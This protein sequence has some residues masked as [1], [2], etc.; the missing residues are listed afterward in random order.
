MVRFTETE[1]ED[2]ESSIHGRKV[3]KTLKENRDFK[4]SCK[5]QD[6]PLQHSAAGGQALPNP[7]WNSHQIQPPSDSSSA[8]NNVQSKPG[9]SLPSPDNP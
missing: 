8:S 4:I 6:I 7:L 2:T 5:S 1:L 9:H 3:L